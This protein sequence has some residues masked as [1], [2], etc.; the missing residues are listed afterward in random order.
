MTVVELSSSVSIVIVI[1]SLITD[2]SLIGW[3]RERKGFRVQFEDYIYHV[4]I[5]LSGI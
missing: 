5:M 1:I 2:G 4:L 3:S